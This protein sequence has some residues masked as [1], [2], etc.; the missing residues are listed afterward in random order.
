VSGP[1]PAPPR[2]G[3]PPHPAGRPTR[4]RILDA[5]LDLFARQGFAA[6]STRQI[7]RAVGL[8]ESGLY[9]HFPSKR[10]VYDALLAEAG[11][12]AVVAALDAA[13]PELERMMA[14]PARCLRM[15]VRRVLAA[16][17]QPRVRRV[18][19]VFV[20]EGGYGSQAGRTDVMAAREEALRR[21]GALFRRWI[22][23]GLVASAAPPE[24]LG[25]E[26]FSPVAYIR[27][28]YLHGQ[29]SAAERRAGHRLADRHVQFFIACMLRTGTDSEA[30]LTGRHARV[31]DT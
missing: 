13:A 24:F 2:R 4:A 20:R 30:R 6:T 9:A 26:L 8:S 11:P 21:L 29:A 19:D 14:E 17:D 12:S 25:W 28:L 23:A 18:M 31:T 10:A 5:A 15:L 22:D 27:L 3:R 16:W 1:P 7:A